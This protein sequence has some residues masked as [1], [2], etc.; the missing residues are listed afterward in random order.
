MVPQIPSPPPMT[1]EGS[2]PSP[3]RCPGQQEG[4]AAGRQV[5]SVPVTGSVAETPR[6]IEGTELGLEYAPFDED[7]GPVDCDCPASCYRGHRGDRSA[8]AAAGNGGWDGGRPSPVTS[9]LTPPALPHPVPLL[10][11]D[12]ALVQQFRVAPS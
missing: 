6:L 8:P 11:Q 1:F 9:A 12:Q 10:T 4:A 2:G 7:D 5:L 3:P